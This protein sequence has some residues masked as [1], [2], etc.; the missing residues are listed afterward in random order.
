MCFLVRGKW[1]Y[2]FKFEI[3]DVPV[4]QLHCPDGDFRVSFQQIPAAFHAQTD[5]GNKKVP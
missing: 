3:S 4:N 1:F 5:R 2:G